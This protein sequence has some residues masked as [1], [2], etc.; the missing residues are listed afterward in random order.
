MFGKKCSLSFRTAPDFSIL[1]I[2][3]SFLD[4]DENN[5]KKEDVVKFKL[6][7]LQ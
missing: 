6:E 5:H 1:K 7:K 3:I 4:S 2:G